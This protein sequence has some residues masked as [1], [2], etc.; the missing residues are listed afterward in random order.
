[1]HDG[2]TTALIPTRPARRLFGMVEHGRGSDGRAS[3]DGEEV[4]MQPM[5]VWLGVVVSVAGFGP[6]RLA[7]QA[8]A[9]GA[10]FRG[11]TFV[12][13]R[14]SSAGALS[15]YGAY[16]IGPLTGFVGIIRTPRT[17]AQT[18][19]AGGGTRVRLAARGGVG[20]FAALA[21]GTGG[22]SIRLYVLPSLRGRGWEVS[23]TATGRVPLVEGGVW[24]ASV[25]P[26]TLSFL[27]TRTL[28][29]G[30]ATVIRRE[31]DGSVVLGAGP[32][33]AVRVAATNVRAEVVRISRAGTVEGRVTASVAF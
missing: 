30:V 4:P 1:M 13:A 15:A 3:R 6:P 26:L 16:G 21:R 25:D 14:Y 24:K 27:L 19:M 2:E 5:I 28:G 29:A 10:T 31:G 17:G 20:V 8:S 7:A 33:A 22:A 18:V 9:G 32:A 11:P 12:L 23:G